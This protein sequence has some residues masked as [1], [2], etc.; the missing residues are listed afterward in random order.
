MKQRLPRVL[1]A[2]GCSAK[3]LCSFS[4]KIRIFKNRNIKAILLR[5]RRR[6]NRRGEPVLTWLKL[7]CFCIASPVYFPYLTMHSLVSEVMQITVEGT[8]PAGEELSQNGDVALC[9][10]VSE[11]LVAQVN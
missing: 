1:C 5:R 2:D 8:S 9:L 7:T 3:M 11:A 10:A 6:K 4:V